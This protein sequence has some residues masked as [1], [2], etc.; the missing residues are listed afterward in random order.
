V[1]DE[2]CEHE[3]TIPAERCE[4]TGE[5]EAASGDDVVRI[6]EQQNSGNKASFRQLLSGGSAK[7]K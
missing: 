4:A 2:V 6:Q 1:N 3:A 7:K 5:G